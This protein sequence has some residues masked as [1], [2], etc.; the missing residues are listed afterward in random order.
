MLFLPLA[1]V[2]VVTAFP[3]GIKERSN[4]D[5]DAGQGRTIVVGSNSRQ[6]NKHRTSWHR[7]GARRRSWRAGAAP[8]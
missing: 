1:S 8:G 6:L 4:E 2:T 7:H 3:V 5:G